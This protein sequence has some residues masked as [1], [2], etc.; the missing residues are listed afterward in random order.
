MVVVHPG[1]PNKAASGFASGMIREPL[2]GVDYALPVT[3][4]TR[5]VVNALI[6]LYEAEGARLG[7]DRAPTIP[8]VSVAMAGVIGT[9]KRAAGDRP[10]ARISVGPDPLV[11]A[12]VTGWP[13]HL[14]AAPAVALGL[15][16]E[17]GMEA[18]IRGYIEDFLVP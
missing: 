18:I 7:D 9:L 13:T 8:K 4:D 11:V 15:P 17:R 6:A 14:D 16:P 3:L 12:I 5:T 1:K 10:P 2:N